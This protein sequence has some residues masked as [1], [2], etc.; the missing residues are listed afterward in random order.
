[1]APTMILKMP[2]VVLIFIGTGE[3]KGFIKYIYSIKQA[4]FIGAILIIQK[5]FDMS[6]S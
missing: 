1:M 3:N 4:G 6:V 2:T 5:Y